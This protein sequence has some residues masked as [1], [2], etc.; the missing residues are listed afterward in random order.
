[1]PQD[2]HPKQDVLAYLRAIPLFSEV[3]DTDL[4]A[5]TSQLIERRYAKDTVVVEEGLAGEYMYVI[6]TGRVK[7]TKASDDGREKIMDFLEAGDF[8][9]EMSLL[10]Q[11]PRSA[12]VRTL[13]VS[14]LM[15]LSRVAFL[16]LLT[17]SPSLSLAVIRV[18]THRLRD[19]D[20]QASSM[21]FHRVEDRVRNL[22][23]RIARVQEDGD[24]LLLTPLLTHQ[25]I[26]DMVGTS[27]ETVTRAIKDLKEEG[28][29]EQRGKR[30]A[31]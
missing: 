27:R 23:Q 24:G 4:E 15:A 12:T 30:Y 11:A 17:R 19:A 16:D 8:F 5:I 9:G 14:Q 18:L 22:F 7:V 13:E 1:M 3:I 6:R 29:L 20:E 21:S 10:D 25:Q 26:A 2:P 28:W 31:I